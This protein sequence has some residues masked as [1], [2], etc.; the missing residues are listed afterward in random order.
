MTFSYLLG[1]TC[2]DSSLRLKLSYLEI[3]NEQLFDLFSNRSD[4]LQIV[5][6]P[7]LGI[8]VN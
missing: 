4:S 6:D 7:N 1:V 2:G 8:I 3:Y 5:E